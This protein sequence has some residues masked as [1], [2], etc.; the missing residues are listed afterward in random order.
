MSS[1]NIGAQPMQPEESG[2]PAPEQHPSTVVDSQVDDN[3]QSAPDGLL[4]PPAHFRPFFT[5]VED[6]QTGEHFHP[7][8]HYIF[9]DDDPDTLTSSI[10]D[11]LQPEGEDPNHRL[12]LLDVAN[13]GK[14][15]KSAHSLSS[16][17]QISQASIAQAPSWTE[18]G[19]E[20][21]TEGL[22]LK[23]EGAEAKKQGGKD[24]ITEEPEDVV[25]RLESDIEVYT[26]RLKHLQ[27][28]MAKSSML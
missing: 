14:T 6:T 18:A 21:A 9:S 5:L 20:A 13:D 27:E 19:A 16:A 1:D 25:Q 22:M 8:V 12:V 15:I 10:I 4:L 28:V 3:Y 24:K 23:V 11:T 7:A 26:E 17:W 2:T